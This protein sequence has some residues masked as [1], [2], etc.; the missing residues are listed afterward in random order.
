VCALA[1][2]SGC[3]AIDDE[4][5]SATAELESAAIGVR[6]SGSWYEYECG[7]TC[8]RKQSFWI[9]LDV[10]DDAYDKEV[11]IV[12]TDDGWETHQVAYAHHEGSLGGGREQWGVDVMLGYF[13]GPFDRMEVEYA[14]FVEMAGTTSWD[15]ANNH[16]VFGRVTRQRPVK[17]L[18]SEVSYQP[19]VGGVLAGTVR[20]YNVAYHKQVTV[21]YTTDDWATSAEVEA[22]WSQGNDWTFRVEGLGT[23]DLPDAVRFAIRYRVAGEEHWDNNDGY[24]YAHRL[25][26]QLYVSTS[27]GSPEEPLSG[28]FSVYA[29]QY[30]D[31]PLERLDVRIDGEPWILGD[32][33]LSWRQLE[34]STL[35][36]ADGEHQIEVR[37]R[38]EGGYQ[39][40]ALGGVFHVENRMTPLGAWDPDFGDMEGEPGVHGWS[41]GVAVDPAGHVYLQWSEPWSYDSQ[42]FFGV[43]RFASFGTD[44]APVAFEP[45]PEDSG[46]YGSAVDRLAADSLGRVYGLQRWPWSVWRWTAAGAIDT[47]FGDGGQLDFG[48]DVDGL[49]LDAIGDLTTGGGYLWITGACPSFVTSCDKVVARFDDTGALAGVLELSAPP[50]APWDYLQPVATWAGGALWVQAY[51]QLLEIGED[52]EGGLAVVAAVPLDPA[53]RPPL[54]DLVATGAGD[55]V[56]LDSSGRLVAIGADGTLRASWTLYSYQLLPGGVR[57]PIQ[58]AVLADGNLAVLDGDSGRLVVFD[59]TFAQS[60]STSAAQ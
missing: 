40:S 23:D 55:L 52:A 12:W 37:A 2:T 32:V 54:Q 15:P 7:Q 58:L 47:G 59:D 44:L 4:T 39:T 43:T 17:L 35:G 30:G 22:S 20:V 1:V 38:L 13:S 57:S 50:D 34:L 24:D 45:L 10:R 25:E 28:I 9:D 51:G 33:G 46:S 41:N 48:A 5:T 29:S 53:V 27:A 3:A 26:P 49:Y 6:D 36:L 21:A 60:P 18:D 8:W 42:S 14:A 56:G 11:A 19:D 31:L 16:H